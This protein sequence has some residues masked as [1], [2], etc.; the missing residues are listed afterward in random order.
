EFREGKFCKRH[1]ATNSTIKSDGGG[2]SDDYVLTWGLSYDKDGK[3]LLVW[4]ACQPNNPIKILKNAD[5]TAPCDEEST[6]AKSRWTELDYPQLS[7]FDRAELYIDSHNNKWVSRNVNLSN[8]A[9][10]IF[11]EKIPGGTKEFNAGSSKF[12]DQDDVDFFSP[13][14]CFVEDKTGKM[15]IGTDSGPIIIED[16]KNIFTSDRCT[17]IKVPRNDGTNRVD[18]LLDGIQV[19]A[20][21]VDGDNRKWIGTLGYGVYL[22]SKDGTEI[23]Q[24]FTVANSPLLSD[25]INSLTLSKTGELFIATDLGI[26]SYQTDAMEANMTENPFENVY[27]FPNPVT[28]NYNGVISIVGL[29][30]DTNI[31]ITDIN[32]TSVYET[33]SRGGMATWDGRNKNGQKVSS[34]IYLVLCA[35][36]DASETVA[37]KIMIINR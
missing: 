34:G 23:L 19:N 10:F 33:T 15:W 6:L 5:G 30:A 22:V 32:G 31:K 20:I 16:P 3:D 36:D 35:L 37:T 18:Y 26:C 25:D 12:I 14:Q 24:H 4:N 17:R 13:A 11:N 2:T 29:Q 7:N 27:A 21:A 28:E 9:T 1:D 8:I